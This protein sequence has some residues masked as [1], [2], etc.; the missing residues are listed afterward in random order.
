MSFSHPEMLFLLLLIL[1]FLLLAI[2]NYRKKSKILSTFISEEAYGKLSVRSGKEID[3]FKSSLI[4]ISM[5]FFIVAMSGPQWGSKFEK[6]EL[7]EKEMLFLLDTSFSM[8]AEDLKPS[9]LKISKEMIKD[10][11]NSLNTDYVG[12]INFAGRA[13]V[14]CPLTIDYEVFKLFT[15]ASQ[16]SPKEE[17][18]TDFF[19]VLS[20]ALKIMKKTPSGEKIVFLIS[21]GEDLENRWEVLLKEYKK[22]KIRI[23]TIGVG[24][25]SGAPIP[26]QNSNGDI[27]GWKKDRKGNIVNSRLNEEGLLKIS[28]VTHGKYFRIADSSSI[29]RLINKIK[30]TEGSILKKKIKSFKI[31]R[32]QYPLGIGIIILLIE[33]ILTSKKLKWKKK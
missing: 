11:V 27:I 13:Y 21:D 12:L 15:D 7:K 17:Q 33:M 2:Y 10:I 1:P 6:I 31:E 14:Q 3:F 8:N 9:R 19:E 26:L 28:S 25:V 20:L 18:G 22:N 29:D 24:S 16:I 32:F 23:F 5:F 4:V 30:K